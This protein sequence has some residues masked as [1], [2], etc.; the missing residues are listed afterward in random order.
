MTDEAPLFE[1]SHSTY[2]NT[3]PDCAFSAKNLDVVMEQTKHDMEHPHRKIYW[4]EELQ[5]GYG[6]P[7]K[8][9]RMWR[10]EPCGESNCH[11]PTYSPLPF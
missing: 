10:T 1:Q 9:Y 11:H 5:D 3:K 8:K 6:R 2:D 4:D 7:I